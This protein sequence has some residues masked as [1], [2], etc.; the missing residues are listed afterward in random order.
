LDFSGVESQN[1]I[2]NLSHHISLIPTLGNR[3][4]L[5]SSPI[6]GLDYAHTAGSD[7]EMENIAP[8]HDNDLPQ[9]LRS[10][11]FPDSVLDNNSEHHPVINGELVFQH[12]V[13]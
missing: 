1:A 8:D 4:D 9:H 10:S 2:V 5:A 7:V 3:R 13:T 11:P 6:H 12:Y